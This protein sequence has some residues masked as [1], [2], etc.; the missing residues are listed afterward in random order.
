MGGIGVA[1]QRC[2]NAVEFVGGDGGPD[3]ATT[4]QY[5]DFRGAVLHSFADLF[6]VV[7]IIVGNR[8]VVRAEVRYLMTCFRE[9]CDYPFVERITTMICSDC[10]AHKTFRQDSHDF[11]GLQ[12]R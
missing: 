12:D 10:Y 9:L 7:G 1:A 5:S 3:T 11:S 6:C 8:A 2:A 4:D